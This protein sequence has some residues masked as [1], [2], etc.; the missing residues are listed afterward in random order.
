[1]TNLEQ[2]MTNLE[3][4]IT[5]FCQAKAWLNRKSG[6]ISDRAALAKFH[7]KAIM[8]LIQAVMDEGKD[9]R[10]VLEILSWCNMVKAQKITINS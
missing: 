5:I 10:E 9:P 4:K 7:K 2:K 3:Q 1:M 8:P 6:R